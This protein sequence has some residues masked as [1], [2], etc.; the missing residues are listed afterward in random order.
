ME[1]KRGRE[2]TKHHNHLHKTITQWNSGMLALSDKLGRV[3]PVEWIVANGTRGISF[4][5]LTY[6]R[7]NGLD[8]ADVQYS[9]RNLTAAAA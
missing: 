1:G 2:M 8:T 6:A 9:Y 7:A 5:V 3:A 4:G